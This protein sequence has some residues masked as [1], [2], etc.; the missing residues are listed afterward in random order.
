MLNVI[1]HVSGRQKRA[2]FLFLDLFLVPVA[3]LLS[4]AIQENSFLPFA[5]LVEIS[6][7]LPFL[8]AVAA[9]FSLMLGI[10][11][12]RLH[13]YELNATIKTAFL[14]ILLGVSMGAL[15]KLANTSTPVGSHVQFAMIYFLISAGSR[16]ILLRVLLFLYRKEKNS[17]RVL[18]YGASATGVQLATALRTHKTIEPV[19]FIDDSTALQ[20][21]NLAGL[22]V[23]APRRAQD[24]IKSRKITRVLLA[25]P[26]LNQ[27]K[28]A[29]IARRLE[30]LGVDVQTLPS[31][32]QLAGE[33]ELADKLSPVLP[34]SLL[35]R[36][37]FG[38]NNVLC[39][40]S[41]AGQTI[42]ISGAGGS[43]GSELCRQLL[44]FEPARLVLFE[45]SE[46]ALYAIDQEL[47]GLLNGAN[48]DIVPVLGSVAD[49]NQVQRVLANQNVDVIV[50]AAAFKHVPLVEANPISGIA[51]NV[52]GTATLAKAA[53]ELGIKRFILVSSDKA[54]RPAGVMGASKR[55]A[56]LVV[57]DLASRSETTVFATVRFGNVL[58]SSGSVVPLF[59]EQ[60][61]RGGPVTLTHED[62][63]RYFMTV[64]ESVRL[65]LLA[66]TFAKG[67]EVFVLDMGEP[68]TIRK[69]ARQLIEASGCTVCDADNPDGDIEIRIT[70]LRPGEKLHEELMIG[71]GMTTTPHPK[72]LCTNDSALSEIEVASALR[73]IRLAIAAGDE[74]AVRAVIARWV[75]QPLRIAR[76][77]NI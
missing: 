55:L 14:A 16:A 9:V 11:G 35:G 38:G 1:K 17:C 64:E 30:A 71:E 37:P 6:L 44:A 53:M 59:Q 29:Q 74:N 26:L 39:S 60:I 76:E 48:I 43:I 52:Q 54:V 45:L 61:A 73:A 75:E 34:N 28:Q 68:I 66:G 51:N 50:H 27:P 22:P 32:A 49:E 70:G 15:A 23:Y 62:V 57:K 65:I 8:I 19:A 69:L 47:R 21:L 10:P 41:Y 7:F 63:T 36:A 31:L 42:F 46:Y 40:E 67:G 20:G 4:I 3:V 13:T 25:M 5:E 18:I 56:E 72:I 2:F 24:L 12:I 33:E 77:G 58:G